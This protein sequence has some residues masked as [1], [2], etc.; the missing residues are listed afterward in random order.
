MLR[1]VSGGHIQLIDDDSRKLFSKKAG[2]IKICHPAFSMDLLHVFHAV[3]PT[4][5]MCGRVIDDAGNFSDMRAKTQHAIQ[6]FQP[7][8]DAFPGLFHVEIWP[9]EKFTEGFELQRLGELSIPCAQD[10]YEAGGLPVCLNLPV[11]NPKNPK[12][13]T[14][15]YESVEEIITKYSGSVGYHNYTVPW[16]ALDTDLDLR[17]EVMAL[18]LPPG[19]RYWLNEGLFDRGLIDGKLAGWRDEIFHQSAEDVSRYLRRIAQRLSQ[20]KRV[21]GYTPFG[22]GTASDWWTFKYDNEPV[23]VQVFTEMYEVADDIHIGQGFQRMIKHLGQPLESEVYHFAGTPMETSL[24]VFENGTA[25]WYK[26]TNE[27]VGQRSDGAIFTDK[28]NQGD[29]VNVWQVYP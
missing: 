16:R 7:A 14:L 26:I 2:C 23:I 17:H 21:I 11:A 6:F 15:V 19:T 9:N 18:Y 13:L 25:S 5:P 20:D 1:N 27:T 10:I 24:A 8:I 22:A 28:G 29:G 12:T 4:S 3:N